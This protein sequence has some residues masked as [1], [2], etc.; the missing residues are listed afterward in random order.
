VN[1][2]DLVDRDADELSE[3]LR[4]RSDQ[5]RPI[6][7]VRSDQVV[8]FATAF[9]AG[10]HVVLLLRVL[11]DWDDLLGSALL[12][13]L[14][15]VLFHYMLTRASATTEVAF[16]GLVTT[17]M[18]SIG[19]AVCGVLGWMVSFVFVK[20]YKQLSWTFLTSDL[21]TV[22]AADEGGGVFH[23]IVGTLEQ[24][25]LAV[26]LVVPIGILTAVY[27]NEIRGRMTVLIRF[28]VDSLAGLPS[29][30]AGLLIITI[31]HYPQL[32]WKGSIA[33]AV[34]T[35]PIMTR[36][37]EEILKTVPDSLRE[38]SLALGAPQWKVVL[39]VVLPTARDGLLTA[40]ILVVARAA[41]E[42]APIILT[43]GFSGA[44]NWNPFKEPQI[45][46]P[47]VVF[48]LIKKPNQTQI[49]RAW[50][51][52]LVLLLL[53]LVLF[54]AARFTAARSTRRLGRR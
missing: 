53:V 22:G 3:P 12:V 54:V 40:A 11:L 39:R 27:L 9:V 34:L 1:S 20:G 44:T 17:V 45:G 29:I 38:A 14:A 15:T 19:A 46:L 10:V 8:D 30:L 33:L 5:P 50:G 31:F 35:L 37:S 43:S 16:D 18:W 49:D 52:A 26:L 4:W 36:T 2:V 41:G 24:V 42:T 32:G 25:G 48:D 6:G 23:G 13:W 47:Y 7:R 21:R 28:F 51:G